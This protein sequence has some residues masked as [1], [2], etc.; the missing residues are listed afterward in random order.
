MAA[1]EAIETIYLE[2]EATSVLFDNNFSSYKHLQLRFN[3]ASDSNFGSGDHAG[4][5]INF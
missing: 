2:S 5:K 3:A 1:I 4:Q